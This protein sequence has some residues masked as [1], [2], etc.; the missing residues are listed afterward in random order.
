MIKSACYV[1]RN[2]FWV[3]GNDIPERTKED[4]HTIMMSLYLKTFN[5]YAGLFV[6]FKAKQLQTS[7]VNP[8]SVIYFLYDPG[9]FFFLSTCLNW[10]LILFYILAKFDFIQLDQMPL[11]HEI[12]SDSVSLFCYSQR[13]HLWIIFKVVLTSE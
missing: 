1:N 12:T 6:W 4:R 3:S 13:C 7:Y 10:N 11:R 8:C 2:A 5:F 9:S